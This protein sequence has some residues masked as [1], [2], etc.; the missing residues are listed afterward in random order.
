VVIGETGI[1]KS[2]YLD[3]IVRRI[4]EKSGNRRVFVGLNKVLD[5]TTNPASPF[6]RTIDDLMD[7]LSVPFREKL[8]EGSKRFLAVCKKVF[9]EKGRTLAKSLVKSFALKLLNKEAV[10]ELE[11][12]VEEFRKTPT[13]DSLA[14]E[15]FSKHRDEFVYDLVFFANRIVE[16]YEELE[17]V[18]VIDQFERAPFVSYGILLGFIRAKPERLHVVV[19]FKIG[20]ESMVNYKY[21]HPELVRLNV[22]FLTLLPMSDKEI[23]EW[24][25]N[26]R[27]RDFSYPELRRIRSLSGGFPFLISQWL[28]HSEKLDI[29]ELQYGREEY[30]IYVEW[31][32]EGL[33]EKCA[34]LL[35]RIST[36]SQPLSVG[37]YEQLADVKTGDCSLMLEELEKNWILVRQEGTFWFRHELIKP[38]IEK[39]L[40]DTER[41]KYHSE[42]AKFFETKI[43]SAIQGHKKAS[44][45]LPLSCAYHFHVAEDYEKSL[46]YNIQCA[47][48]CQNTGALDLAEDCYLRAIDD[49]EE[50]KKEEVMMA[51]KGDLARV[52]S[53]WGRLDDAYKTHAELRKYF[54]DKKDRQH[55]AVAL[56]NLAMIEQRQGNYEEAK[57][58]YNETLKIEQ[59]LRD[60]LEIAKTTHNLATIEQEQGNYDGAKKLYNESLKIK[61]ELGDKSGIAKTTHNLAM[62]EQRQGNY[63][64]AKKLFNES[65]K[66]KQELE[67]KL[68][69]AATTHQ[70]ATIEQEQGNYDGAKKLYNENLKIEQELGDKSGIAKTTHNLAMI[71]QRQGNYDGAKKLFNESLKIEQE[72]GDKL[73]IATSLAALGVL[74]ATT[75]QSENAIEYLSEAAYLFHQLGASYEKQAM[76]DFA[77]TA[78]ILEE[79]KLNE[80]ISKMPEQK[81]KYL[82]ETIEKAK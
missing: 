13:I 43:S 66:I 33:S 20:K 34:L 25:L 58:L 29:E 31:C 32:F 2:S 49:A 18:L 16:E 45:Q 12:V 8:E 54:R 65:L 35:R 51:A 46:S 22:R 19:S 40:S 78:S 79:K 9:S 3:E 1:G 10:E 68:G 17:F 70:L 69:I 72:L 64:G 48:F 7:N 27:E 53:I 14:E 21:I 28:M 73:G 15:F 82:I 42:A 61:Q 80:I 76:M 6:V 5:G 55:E 41:R 26:S 39:K 38:C 77:R 60:K 81:K 63:D 67:D 74:F 50:L 24:I 37:D 59:E 56:H 23:G 71:E 62:I 44:L 30:C 4:R 36:L 75:K 11:K 47:E 52:Y 57:K